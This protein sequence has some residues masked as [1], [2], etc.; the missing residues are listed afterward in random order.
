MS[1]GLTLSSLHYAELLLQVLGS[2]RA[3]TSLNQDGLNSLICLHFVF[4]NLGTQRYVCILKS[5]PWDLR[6]GLLSGVVSYQQRE[7]SAT[8]RPVSALVS[9]LWLMTPLK[10]DESSPT[11]WSQL[12]W[13]SPNIPEW[14]DF[15]FTHLITAMVKRWD[16]ISFSLE[17]QGKKKVLN[18]PSIKIVGG[19]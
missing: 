9:G 11:K 18:V 2:L 5:F 15:I 3:A 4:K 19:F 6:T 13:N 12:P 17:V 7:S 16:V 14:L 10:T 8:L 1:V